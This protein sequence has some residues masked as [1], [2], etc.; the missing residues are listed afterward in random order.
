MQIEFKD[1]KDNTS[2]SIIS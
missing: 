2:N 1:S